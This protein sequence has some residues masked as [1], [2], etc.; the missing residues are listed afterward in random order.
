MKCPKCEEERFRVLDT[1]TYDTGY[2][3]MRICLA[4]GHRFRTWENIDDEPEGREGGH[5]EATA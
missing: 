1:R 2:T 4:C 5:A 3:R